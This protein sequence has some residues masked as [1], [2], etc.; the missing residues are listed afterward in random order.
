MNGKEID[1]SKQILLTAVSQVSNTG[2][3]F[4]ADRTSAMNWGHEPVLLKKIYASVTI[5]GLSAA[6]YQVYTLDSHGN[7]DKLIYRS[8]E[9]ESVLHFRITYASE[10]PWFYIVQM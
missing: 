7:E 8:K 2:A 5:K 3:V 1:K 4:S 6:K 10:T 9:S